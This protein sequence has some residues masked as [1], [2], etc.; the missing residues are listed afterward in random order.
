PHPDI[1][2]AVAYG[3]D[4]LIHGTAIRHH[5]ELSTVGHQCMRDMADAL[6]QQGIEVLDAPVSGGPRGEAR[7]RLICFVAAKQESF[8]IARPVLELMSDRLFHV[9]HEPGQSQVLKLANNLLGAANLTIASEMMSLAMAAGIDPQAAIDVINVST[10]RNRATEEIFQSQI[11]NGSFKLGARLNI[12]QKD[13]SLAI[14]EAKR[15]GVSHRA[16]EG[17]Q[18]VW[19]AA[20]AA[21]R[22][23]EDL[24]RIFEYIASKPRDGG[25]EN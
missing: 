8:D 19:E 2:R 9:G 16:A 12:L 21:G 15:L 17:V 3:E 7:G 6:E 10:G 14:A 20:V 13:V 25:H 24:S 23:Q 5:V 4:G 1:S 18:A 11:L 22:G